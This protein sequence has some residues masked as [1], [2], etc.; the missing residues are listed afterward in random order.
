MTILVIILLALNIPLSIFFYNRI[1][2]RWLN[3]KKYDQVNKPTEVSHIDRF[4]NKWYAYSAHM[5]L[6]VKR[7]REANRAMAMAEM[8]ITKERLERWLSEI[9]Q[10]ARVNNYNKVIAIAQNILDRMNVAAELV[11]LEHLANCLFL[12]EG[13]EPQETTQF[14]YDKKKEI[15]Q[16]DSETHAFFLHAALSTIRN[17][18]DLSR[19]DLASFLKVK[20]MERSVLTTNQSMNG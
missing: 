13:E 14:W 4:G 9:Q 1:K 2:W 5:A 15:W 16:N 18:Q 12:L 10:N 20:E 17:L 8:A 19:Q 6:P 7:Y 3:R 11:T